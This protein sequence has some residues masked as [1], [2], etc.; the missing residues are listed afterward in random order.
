MNY[1]LYA[2]FLLFDK[3]YNEKGKWYKSN[4]IGMVESVS[5]K[6]ISG[7]VKLLAY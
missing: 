3:E 5:K 1:N 4:L 2:F 7:E 6:K